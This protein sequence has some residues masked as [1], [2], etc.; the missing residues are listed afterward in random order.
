LRS[1]ARERIG[2]W[3][4]RLRERR[5]A[6]KKTQERESC[7]GPRSFCYREAQKILL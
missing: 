4:H 2:L 6:R 3:R 5:D 1:N 7:R